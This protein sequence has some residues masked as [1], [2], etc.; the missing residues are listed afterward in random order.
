MSADSVILSQ[1]TCAEQQE[2]VLDASQLDRYVKLTAAYLE[3]LLAYLKTKWLHL[4]SNQEIEDLALKTIRSAAINYDKCNRKDDPFPWIRKISINHVLDQLR[5][6]D[7][8]N[9]TNFTDLAGTIN[10]CFDAEQQLICREQSRKNEIW[11]KSIREA[12]N[13]LPGHLRC[14]LDAALF[15]GMTHN[16]IANREKI[17][18]DAVRKRL[19]QAKSIVKSEAVRLAVSHRLAK[20]TSDRQMALFDE[21]FSEKPKPIAIENLSGVLMWYNLAFSEKINKVNRICDMESL[22]GRA[23]Y[24]QVNKVIERHKYFF[25]PAVLKVSCQ[26]QPVRINALLLETEENCKIAKVWII[27]GLF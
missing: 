6:I 10:E 19:Y 5:K 13:C 17:G 1:D 16:Q 23:C 26:A 27:D 3:T 4:L 11:E 24:R 22:L 25:G 18:I 21:F 14:V 8:R 2:R 12:I 7:V 15:E 20:L 9:R